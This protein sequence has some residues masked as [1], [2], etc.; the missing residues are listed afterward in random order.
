MVLSTVWLLII[1]KFF[2][3]QQLLDALCNF[4]DAIR[5]DAQNLRKLSD[6]GKGDK[7]LKY[8]SFD[9]RKV[10]EILK[11]QLKLVLWNLVLWTVKFNRT[12]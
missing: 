1:E 7:N 6:D 9:K 4:N 12:S 8:L 5:K 3:F 10:S 11:F 2:D